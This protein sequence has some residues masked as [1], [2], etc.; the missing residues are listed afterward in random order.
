MAR[1]YAKRRPAA[2]S[3]KRGKKK[4]SVSKVFWL[5][6][7]LLLGVFVTFLLIVTRNPNQA[8]LEKLAPKPPI[9]SVKKAAPENE[10]PTFEFY[11]ILPEKQITPTKPIEKKAPP[12][13]PAEQNYWVQV[14][15]FQNF[16]DADQLKAELA[17]LGFP[18][19]I[20]TVTIDNQTWY[21][22]RSGPFPT[23]ED[24]QAAQQQFQEADITTQ[25]VTG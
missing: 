8:D 13:P 7:I 9:A 23:Q 11:D 21:R 15:S 2:K 14:G 6:I 25:V 1:D 18:A 17:L 19:L 20:E 5:V 3:K 4:S 10:M 22:V 12:P 24:A 16:T